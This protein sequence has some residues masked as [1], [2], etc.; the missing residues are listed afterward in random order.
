MFNERYYCDAVKTSKTNEFLNVVQGNTTVTEY[1][2]KFDGLAKFAFDM[3]PMDVA[4]KEQF[5]Q[6]LNFGIAQDVRI[7]PVH[8]ISTY[9]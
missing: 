8:E 5:I 4:Q 9:D 1:V 3:V 7:A 6:G 2:N